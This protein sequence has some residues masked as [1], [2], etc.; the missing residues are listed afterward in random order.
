MRRVAA[1]ASIKDIARR[2]GVSHS[3]VSR[4]L[5]GDRRISAATAARI[6]EV[7]AA[8]G[9]VPHAAARALVTCRSAVVGLV[10]TTLADPFV[11][12]I[13]AGVEEAATLSGYS[14]LLATSANE[15]RRELAVVRMLAERRVDGLIVTAS[16]LG[17]RYG[18]L[19]Q[20]LG[21]PV[22]LIN[23]QAIGDY[24]SSVRIDDFGGAKEVTAFLLSLGHR[25]LAFV[26]CPDRP[27][28]HSLRRSGF[29]AAC[30][31]LGPEEVCWQTL[32]PSGQDDLERG[33]GG[34]EMALK[35]RPRPTALVCYNDMT[36]IGALLSAREHGLNVPA[37]ISIVGFDD[38]REATF[39][40]PPLTTVHQPR[41]EM[42]RSA[43][44][45]LQG[46]LAGQ[47]GRD[48][49]VPARLIVR[50]SAGPPACSAAQLHDR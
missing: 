25:S 20:K 50:S 6:R 8:V 3:T 49:L 23:N 31:E 44:E 22:V 24:A 37:D 9:Y 5:R 33:A 40:C 26:G 15:E 34:L 17:E 11:A 19:L 4:A 35:L 14:V 18:E 46:L 16:R 47:P 28:S 12:E 29:E 41:R 38:I 42:G 39:V 48:V 7:A 21:V 30:S 36:A 10:V 45:M 13:V 32:L 27:R 1:R 43:F 2:A